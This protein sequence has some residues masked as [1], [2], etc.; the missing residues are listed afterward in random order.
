LDN[1]TAYGVPRSAMFR[2]WLADC[3]ERSRVWQQCHQD[4][5]G[6]NTMY[7]PHRRGR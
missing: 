6:Q 4:V 2:F 3:G 7:G 1:V 5:L